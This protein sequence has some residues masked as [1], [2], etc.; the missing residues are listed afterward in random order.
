MRIFGPPKKT[1]VKEQKAKEYAKQAAKAKAKKASVPTRYRIKQAG[2]A[3]RSC[4]NA[5]INA[6]LAP[7]YVASVFFD[8]KDLN[9][10]PTSF[11]G[12]ES[13][14]AAQSNAVQ[15]DI[16]VSSTPPVVKVG[17]RSPS[18]PQSTSPSSSSSSSSS[19]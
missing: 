2:R 17:D 15:Q 5:V 13:N 4:V 9:D 19:S 1:R 11:F 8:K 7:V 14:S 18:T 6:A 16:T 10:N 12:H 3:L